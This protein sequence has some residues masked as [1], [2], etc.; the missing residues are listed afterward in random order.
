M[1]RK[2][3]PEETRYTKKGLLD[4]KKRIS[5]YKEKLQ[6]MEE[7]NAFISKWKDYLVRRDKAIAE[8]EKKGQQDAMEDLKNVIKFEQETISNQELQ[9]VEGIETK[10]KG[11]KNGI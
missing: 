11:G 10:Q 5:E 9:L 4:R 6:Y 2:L 7:S 1:K 8:Q 3:T